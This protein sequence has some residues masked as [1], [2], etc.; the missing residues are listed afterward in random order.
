VAYSPQA[1]K[2]TP[3]DAIGY[4]GAVLAATLS[5]WATFM[6]RDAID[7][8]LNPFRPDRFVM[9]VLVTLPFSVAA[10]ASA[11]APFLIARKIAEWTGIQAAWYYAVSGA[12]T[13][14]VLV[15]L[16]F[17]LSGAWEPEVPFLQG[18]L[19]AVANAGP[20]FMLCGAIA[21]LTFWRICRRPARAL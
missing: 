8:G 3:G 19:S 6:I 5:F 21:G 4:L 7:T 18:T 14:L 12:L 11:L 15:P 9:M 17:A 2:T 20:W 16:G 1:N 10:A 13:G